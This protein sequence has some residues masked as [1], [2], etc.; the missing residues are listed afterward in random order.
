[1]STL[2][3]T[4]TENILLPPLTLPS[5]PPLKVELSGLQG[6]LQLEIDTVLGLIENPAVGEIVQTILNKVRRLFEKLEIIESN[7]RK[8]DTLVENLAILDMLR[9][10]I[11]SLNDF[12]EARALQNEEVDQEFTDVLDGISYAIS[13]DLKRIY[14]RELAGSITECTI[15]VVYGKIVYAN[16]LLTNCLQQTT[17]TLLGMFNP[18]IDP[19]LLFDYFE[20][21]ERQSQLL[22]NDLV[23]LMRV[24]REAEEERSFATLRKVEES[25]IKF[26][27]GSMQYLM[28]RDWRGYERLTLAL[29]TALESNGDTKDLLHQFSCYLEVLYGDVKMRAALKDTF[30]TLGDKE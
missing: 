16:G 22:C 9:Y 18:S 6:R 20:E 17:L 5:Q 15:P 10:D 2:V 3:E 4:T 23:S 30:N 27:E 12:I 21:R 14:E 1:M 25:A 24:V 8:L 28:Y 19:A 26:R 13:H 7:L 11:R 29:I